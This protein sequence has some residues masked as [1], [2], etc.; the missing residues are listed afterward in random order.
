MPKRQVELLVLA[1]YL[2]E[3]GRLEDTFKPAVDTQSFD[4]LR[5]DSDGEDSLI[6]LHQ[7]SASFTAQLLGL[8]EIGQVIHHI[9]ERWDG[10]GYPD[11]LSGRGIPYES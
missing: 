6:L 7:R 8:R 5:R 11:A 1:S 10:R 2:V 4:G 9:D 3:S